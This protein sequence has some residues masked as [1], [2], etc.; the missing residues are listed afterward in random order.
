M[1]FT[2]KDFRD[3]VRLLEQHPEWRAE[4]RQLLLTEEILT[5]PQVVRELAEEVR[6]LVE[7][8]R[9]AEERLERAYGIRVDMSAERGARQFQIGLLSG[10]G[11]RVEPG[12]P[13]GA[14]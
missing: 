4:L 9:R 13:V 12:E 3:L 5:L 11:E 7:A 14:P 10:Q 6:L 8:Q 2:V 1:A